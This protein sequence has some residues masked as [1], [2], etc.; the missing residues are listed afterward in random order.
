MNK[1][2]HMLTKLCSNCGL[3][4][5]LSAFLQ[6]S[7]SRGAVYGNIC[8]SCRK[9][10]KDNVKTTT[11]HESSTSSTGVKIDSKVKV[12]GD[13]DKRQRVQQVEELYHEGRDDREALQNKT[14]LKTKTIASEERKHR[15]K[16]LLKFL[17]KQVK[18]GDSPK[19]FGGQQQTIKEGEIDLTAPFIDTQITGKIK[20]TSAR[21]QQMRALFGNTPLLKNAERAAAKIDPNNHLSQEDEID[22]IDKTVGPGSRKS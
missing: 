1:S 6:M 5:P 21:F 15:E 20:F 4:K 8:S 2:Q 12:Q 9:T 13:I 7:D 17:D 10:S 19:V 11:D 3:K 22:I 14:D 16:T 18:T